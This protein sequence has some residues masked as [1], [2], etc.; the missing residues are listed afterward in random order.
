MILPP[1]LLDVVLLGEDEEAP[2]DAEEEEDGSDDE[3]TLSQG[4]VTLL[5]ITNSDNEETCKA[6]AHEKA[7]KSDV[8]YAAW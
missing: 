7:C 4:M 1:H 6:A 8:Q 2:A 3:G 5:N